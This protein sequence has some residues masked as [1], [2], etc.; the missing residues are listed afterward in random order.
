MLRQRSISAVGVVLFAAIPALLG[1]PVFAAALAIITVLGI[2][3]LVRALHGRIDPTTRLLAYLAGVA[4]IV[5]AALAGTGPALTAIITLFVILAL[6]AG[7]L[8]TA[9][10]AGL[11]SWSAGVV[12]VVYVALPLAYAVALR[13][14]HGPASQPWVNQVSGWLAGDTGVGLAWI[15]V[16]FAVTWLTDTAAYLAGRSF[17]KTKLAPKLSPGKTRVGSVA[18]LVA[19]VLAGPLAAWVFGAP[20]GIVT[21]ACLGLALSVT[22]E[23]GDLGESLIKRNL[24]IKDMGSLIP[25]HG[26]VLDRID[27]LLFTFPVTF[28]L[29]RLLEWVG[30]T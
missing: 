29:V 25:G 9:V 10:E 12:A 1:G 14:L 7:V 22:G 17:G 16:V 20:V 6:V 15:G 24:G 5:S 21:A 3:E 26:G 27:A 18:G 8:R 19:G 4:L 13:N 28:L 11:A 2:H 23:L 30:W